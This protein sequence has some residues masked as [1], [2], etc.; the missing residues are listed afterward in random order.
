MPQ[1]KNNIYPHKALTIYRANKR[2]ILELGTSFTNNSNKR[3]QN[4]LTTIINQALRKATGCTKTT[5]LNTLHALASEVP[6]KIRNYFTTRKELTKDIVFSRP[7]RNQ[8]MKHY[9]TNYKKRKKSY[10]E[11]LFEKDLRIYKN[12]WLARHNNIKV[13]I[14]IDTSLTNEIPKKTN[15]NK[16]I[17]KQ[18]TIEKIKQWDQNRPTIYTDGSIIND[19]AGIG[20]YIK[21]KNTHSYYEYNIKNYASIT[22]TEII[23]LHETLKKADEMNLHQPIIFTDSLTAC[24]I[25]EKAQSQLFIEEIIYEIIRLG[26]KTKLN[27]TWIPSHIVK[28]ETILQT[29]SR[30]EAQYPKI[31]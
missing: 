4:S 20:I 10:Q 16:E 13:K 29:I 23:A 14:P 6:F 24:K 2:N 28:G 15:T 7:I 12:L 31:K 17:M 9:K 3:N 26:I 5:P 11:T 21:S 1:K 22:T 18:I 8:L 19:K 25:I 27:I 30:K